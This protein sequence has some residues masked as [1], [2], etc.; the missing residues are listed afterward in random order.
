MINSQDLSVCA[1]GIDPSQVPE[2]LAAFQALPCTR[3]F[4]DPR[5]YAEPSPWQVRQLVR[6]TGWSIAQVAKITGAA[7]NDKTA[8]SKVR[9]WMAPPMAK[10]HQKIPYG[11]WVML[12]LEAKLLEYRA[13]IE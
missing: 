12:L 3:F 13:T 10:N 4:T 8:S 11:A 7:V 6:L 5:G 1:S 2:T 9:S